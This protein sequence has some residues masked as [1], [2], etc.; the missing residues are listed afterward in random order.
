MFGR[1]AIACGIVG[2]LYV[3]ALSVQHAFTP[4]ATSTT[5]LTPRQVDDC[6]DD[7][8]QRSI[9]ERWPDGELQRCRAMC[10]GKGANGG[11][12]KRE[13]PSKITVA[14]ATPAAPP[15]IA[16]RPAQVK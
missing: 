13:V 7:C 4:S 5:P 12:Q 14:P 16:P 8:E 9:V 11:A 3:L 2:V 6:S 10:R 15:P 1:I